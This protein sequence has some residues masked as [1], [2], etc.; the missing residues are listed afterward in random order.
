VSPSSILD[1]D[2]AKQAAAKFDIFDGKLPDLDPL[3][4]VKAE[5]LLANNKITPFDSSKYIQTLFNPLAGK[6]PTC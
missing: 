5:Y 4:R 6:T 3:Q 1:M 2:D